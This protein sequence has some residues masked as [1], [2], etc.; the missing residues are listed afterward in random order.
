MFLPRTVQQLSTN[1]LTA[2]AV[3]DCTRS[4]TREENKKSNWPQNFLRTR[5]GKCT[6]GMSYF[7]SSSIS[8]RDD[9]SLEPALMSVRTWQPDR[10]HGEQNKTSKKHRE[11]P[12]QLQKCLKH[13]QS[14]HRCNPW[15]SHA[16]CTNGKQDQ[17][18][19]NRYA[20]LDAQISSWDSRVCGWKW[21][22]SAYLEKKM[23][24]ASESQTWKSEDKRCQH[25]RN[26]IPT[27][28]TI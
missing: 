21:I 9:L 26:V 20:S 27:S 28:I 19:I 18:N 13:N 2:A 17:Y 1:R 10:F 16:Q 4:Q 6:L 22:R 8:H 7:S 14:T 24:L 12:C 25:I 23:T 5:S 3:F 15:H 11:E